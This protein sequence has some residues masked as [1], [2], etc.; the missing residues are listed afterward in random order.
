MS[1]HK[2]FW[3]YHLR[4]HNEPI[5]L[6]SSSL[7][8]PL[9]LKLR[10]LF[11]VLDLFF[12]LLCSELSRLGLF[13]RPRQPRQDLPD[14]LQPEQ[15]VLA[16]LEQLVVGV[17]PVQRESEEGLLRANRTTRRG[18][19]ATTATGFRRRHRPVL[20]AGRGQKFGLDFRELLREI[21]REIFKISF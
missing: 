10:H 14:W 1:F 20:L 3:K 11:K 7:F 6:R 13:V 16:Q 8:T 4:F 18:R 21:F 2:R 5:L 19:P 9:S 17:S 12:N 15:P